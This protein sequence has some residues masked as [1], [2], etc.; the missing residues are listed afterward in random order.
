MMKL[1]HFKEVKHEALAGRKKEGAAL[2]H[3]TGER[4]NKSQN[5]SPTTW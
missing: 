4:I 2:I 5:F 1:I 3:Q